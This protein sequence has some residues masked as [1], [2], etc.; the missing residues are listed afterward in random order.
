M[1]NGIADIP[2]LDDVDVNNLSKE[3]YVSLVM[4]P[5]K[6]LASTFRDQM[7]AGQSN[8]ASNQYRESF[9][10]E[11]IRSANEVIFLLFPVFL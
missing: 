4:E 2:D 8:G 10:D 6:N 9:Y 5:Q 11:V 1:A 7:T 3:D